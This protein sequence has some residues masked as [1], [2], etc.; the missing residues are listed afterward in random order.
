MITFITDYFANGMI[1][2]Q[3]RS[4][5]KPLIRSMA[6]LMKPAQFN[7]RPL[8]NSVLRDRWLNG[9]VIQANEHGLH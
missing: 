3:N 7:E 4:T 1:I 2:R 9:Y 5:Q 6:C 8:K